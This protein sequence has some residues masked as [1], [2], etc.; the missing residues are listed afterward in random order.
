MLK[1]L[2]LNT[3]IMFGKQLIPAQYDVVKKNKTTI[4]L[5]QTYSDAMVKMGITDP[6]TFFEKV[7]E[8]GGTYIGRGTVK[9]ANLPGPDDERVVVRQYR[10]GGCLQ[11]YVSDLYLGRSR[12]FREL[13]LTNQAAERGIPTVEIVAA[14]H[15]KVW[16]GFH[17]GHLV[18]KEIKGGKDLGTYFTGLEQPLERAKVFEKRKVINLVGY[19]IRRM[20]DAGIFHADLN[21]KN[22]VVQPGNTGTLRV[23]LIDFDQS[24]IRE[25]LS[26]RKRRQNLMRLNRSAQKFKKSGISI[27]RTDAVRFLRAYYRRDAGIFREVLEDLNRQY[28]RH[29]YFH[30]LG[31]RMVSFLG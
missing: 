5:K 16:W 29:I 7:S 28:S 31:A 24:V 23:F 4:A 25:S 22:I 11:K 18:S 26:E 13:W 10:R 9:I 1:R 17:R 2:F 19:L 12:P 6:D 3:T 20:H 8:E 27:T 30:D 14:C 21:L 15:T